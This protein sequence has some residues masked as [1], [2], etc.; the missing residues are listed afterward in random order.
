MLKFFK[1]FHYEICSYLFL[2][3]F[4]TMLQADGGSSTEAK[5]GVEIKSRDIGLSFS[6]PAK[7]KHKKNKEAT[8]TSTSPPS[9]SKTH[10][11]TAEVS[12][13]SSLKIVL[14]V[15]LISVIV[16]IYLGKRY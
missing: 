14:G 13:I 10:T 16:G 8:T 5:D 6:A 9:S 15:A 1:T 2:V 7:R 3:E 11:Q 12:S 4:G